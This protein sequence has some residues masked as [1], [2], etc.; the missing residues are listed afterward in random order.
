MPNYRQG[1]RRDDL[2][3]PVETGDSHMYGYLSIR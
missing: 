1:R 3:G 2:P